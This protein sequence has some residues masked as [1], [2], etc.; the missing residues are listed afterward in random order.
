VAYN[1]DLQ[2][3]ELDHD[4]YIDVMRS[5]VDGGDVS[6]VLTVSHGGLRVT[7]PM[8]DANVADLVIAL[9]NLQRKGFAVVST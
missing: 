9:R 3:I 7:I 5:T 6:W 1:Y 4:R 2:Q 8:T